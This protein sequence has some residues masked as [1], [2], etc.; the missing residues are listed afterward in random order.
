M[1]PIAH[2]ELGDEELTAVQDI[3]ESGMIADGP[4]VRSFE[5]EF[6]DFCGT[7]QAVATTNGTTALHTA[8]KS[9]GIGNDDRVLTTPFS[10]VASA[11][12]IRFVGAEPVFGDIDPETYN[13]DPET[14]KDILEKQ[15]I[16]AIL[17]VHLYG[18][19]A[20]LNLLVDL[21]DDYDIPLIEDAAQAHGA[22]VG[23]KRV[24]SIGDVG[25]FSFYPTKNM[26]TAEGGMITTDS[27][28]VADKAEVF[29]NHGRSET[30][31]EHVELGHNFRMTSI[32]AAIG[33]IQLER[34]PDLIE[35]RRQNAN[36]LTANLEGTGIELPSIPSDR[37]H[38]YHQYT[39][40]CKKRDQLETFLEKRDIGTGIYYPRCIHKQPAY[41]HIKHTAPVA[42]R[43]AHEVL[44]LPVHPHVSNQDIEQISDAIQSFEEGVGQ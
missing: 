34:L 27:K 30:G 4:E 23:G 33:R 42:E 10:F 20:N 43:A 11:N 29:I 40:R 32:A 7:D 19:P 41:D 26:T 21:A 6:A 13:L 24:G 5:A 22:K 2:P 14:T 28:S 36:Q 17:A 35:K 25:C 16:D 38:V 3:M 39:I 15:D 9:V 44:S 31:Y 8:L 1:I 12:A 37:M 18:L